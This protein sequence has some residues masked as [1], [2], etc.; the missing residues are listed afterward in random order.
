MYYLFLQVIRMGLIFIFLPVMRMRNKWLGWKEAFVIGFSGLRGAVSLVLALEVGGNSDI[1]DD[2]R[3]RVVLW[4]TGIVAL[5]LRII[6]F[7][8]KPCTSLLNLGCAKK[9]R[10]DFLQRACALMVQRT[11]K[12]SGNL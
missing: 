8:V 1:N 9:S 2:V 3:P 7:L 5:S 12:I 4:V 11:L 6:G 10:V